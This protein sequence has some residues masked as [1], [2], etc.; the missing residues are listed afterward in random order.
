MLHTNQSL[1]T[2]YFFTCSMGKIRYIKSKERGLFGRLGALFY[3]RNIRYEILG[4]KYQKFH[5]LLYIVISTSHF[6][7]L[8]GLE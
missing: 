1:N 8:L 3:H 7:Y 5:I 6:Q 2:N 4:L